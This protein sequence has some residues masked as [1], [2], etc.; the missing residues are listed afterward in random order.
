MKIKKR[1]YHPNGTM[2]IEEVEVSEDYFSEPEQPPYV[3]SLE[4]R[5]AALEMVQ[6]ANMGVKVNV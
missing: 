1:V 2:T 4:D 3:P 5:I 6:L